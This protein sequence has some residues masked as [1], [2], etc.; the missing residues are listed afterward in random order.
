MSRKSSLVELSK[1]YEKVLMEQNIGIESSAQD[2]LIKNAHR[3]YEKEEEQSAEQMANLANQID[4]KREECPKCKGGNCTD[5]KTISFVAPKV[6]ENTPKVEGEEDCEE[7]DPNMKAHEDSNLDMAKTETFKIKKACETLCRAMQG[8]CK[9]E[10]WMLAK[11]VKASDYLCSVAN[12]LEYDNYEKSVEQPAQDF[13]NDM[14]LITKITGMLNGEGKE[15]NEAVLK[16]AIFNL[17]L[18]NNK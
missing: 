3:P 4:A 6:E 13:S 15:V 16:R 10:P 18:I 7:C 5:H 8:A 9:V 12:V 17:E 11:L 1:E 14:H 2:T